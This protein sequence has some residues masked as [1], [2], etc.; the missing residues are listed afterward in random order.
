MKQIA[1]NSGKMS[2]P[3]GK[4]MSVFSEKLNCL[5]REKKMAEAKKLLLAEV[6]KYSNEYFL[7]T[8]LAQTC[9][10]LGEYDSALEFS[11]RAISICN[12]DVLVLYNHATALIKTESY[13]EALPFCQQILRKSA[14]VIARN[15]EGIKWAKSI[16]NDTMYL[17]SVVLFQ[18]GKYGQ[19][20]QVLKQ[21]LTLRQRGLYSDYSK[22]Q[23]LKRMK[24]IELTIAQ[25]KNKQLT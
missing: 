6:E 17:K 2:N 5:W 16:R 7:W 12:D 1:H 15:G 25:N 11:N 4:E 21:F 20:L 10:G 19:A 14:V 23:L 18:I 22:R 13:K 9:S 24:M 8:S 3:S